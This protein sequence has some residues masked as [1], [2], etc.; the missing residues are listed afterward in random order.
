[1]IDIKR[2]SIV[3]ALILSVFVL[4]IGANHAHAVAERGAST[5]TANL[6]VPRNESGTPAKET[7]YYY[8]TI[9]K[10]MQYDARGAE[11]SLSVEQPKIAKADFHS[12]AQLAVSSKDRKH[13]VEA[14]W[15]ATRSTDGSSTTR[16]FIFF[17]V[18]KGAGNR[19][20]QCYDLGCG[21]VHTSK[22]HTPGM[23]LK[24]GTNL[25]IKIIYS[26]ERWEIHVNDELLGYYPTALWGGKFTRAGGIQAFGEVASSSKTG[27][28][29]RY[30]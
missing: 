30:G 28:R 24:P 23:V 10:A 4:G 20:G 21:F 17:W 7:C 6:C 13:T 27:T 29:N 8:N 15:K 1:M 11:V 16:L 22:K 18:N 9:S 5:T 12:L 14:G 19:G 3:T 25:K 26:N 2:S